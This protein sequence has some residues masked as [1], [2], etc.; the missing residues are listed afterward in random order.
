MFF[1]VFAK[2]PMD[3]QEGVRYRYCILEKGGSQD[4]MKTLV[5]FLGRRPGTQPFHKELGLA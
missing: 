2:S 4:E 3:Y 5:E 1:T